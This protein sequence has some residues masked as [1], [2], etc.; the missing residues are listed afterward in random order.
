[1]YIH[2]LQPD[3]AANANAVEING[4]RAAALDD[5]AAEDSHVFQRDV[6]L[7]H[8]LRDDEV[9]ENR[10]IFQRRSGLFNDRFFRALA[11]AVERD[12]R[13]R[14]GDG[15]ERAE[16]AV[17]IAGH[18]TGLRGC[19]H[20]ALCPRGDGGGIRKGVRAFLVRGKPRRAGEHRRRLGAGDRLIRAEQPA[21]ALR[22]ARRHG[23]CNLGME[24]V[25]LRHVGKGNSA[26]RREAQ[27][28]VHQLDKLRAGHGAV[29][30]KA[31]VAIAVDQALVLPFV[32]RFFRPMPGGVAE[33]GGCGDRGQQHRRQHRQR[34]QPL[35][36]CVFLH[37]L[38]P[39]IL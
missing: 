12:H 5:H 13:L 23:F 18:V 14:T 22:V 39:Y 9:A 38:S 36:Q 30:L 34:Q 32:E 17:G 27:R 24:P 29:R 35:K 26:L 31:A 3:R 8:A 1:M 7:A 6:S 4:V 28:A 15:A 37:A 25:A 21:A 10:L 2:L 16:R 33:C 11:H 20:A 19:A